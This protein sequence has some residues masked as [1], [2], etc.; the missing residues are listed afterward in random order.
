MKNVAKIIYLKEKGIIKK[1]TIALKKDLTTSIPTPMINQVGL[2]L[3]VYN[4]RK[5]FLKVEVTFQ[6]R[7]SVLKNAYR[8]TML[9]GMFFLAA[10]HAVKSLNIKNRLKEN[11]A[12]KNV[13]INL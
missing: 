11:I 13:I 3:N 10:I 7:T 6:K 1:S 2:Q 12:L 5:S 8:I 9:V 4:V